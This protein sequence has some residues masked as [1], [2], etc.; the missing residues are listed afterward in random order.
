MQ[1]DT[2]GGLGLPLPVAPCQVSQRPSSAPDRRLLVDLRHG[3][4]SAPSDLPASIGRQLQF[5]VYRASS[6]GLGC[7]IG[8]RVSCRA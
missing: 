7:L 8:L 3:D 1:P 4:S 2:F 5:R 6:E